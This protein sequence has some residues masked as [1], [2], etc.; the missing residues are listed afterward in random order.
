MFVAFF[1]E[2]LT[3]QQQQHHF[4]TSVTMTT[5]LNWQPPDVANAFYSEACTVTILVIKH[6][7]SSLQLNKWLFT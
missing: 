1:S 3:W 6:F 7:Q 4:A 2:T 5:N